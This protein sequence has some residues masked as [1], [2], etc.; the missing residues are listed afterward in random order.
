VT[1]PETRRFR[2]NLHLDKKNGWIAGVCAGIARRTGV[3]PV[4]VRAAAIVSGVFLP[5]I[6]IA[7]YLLAWLLLD[8]R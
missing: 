7:A 4:I 1:A 3:D 5:K 2:L 6:T 8:K